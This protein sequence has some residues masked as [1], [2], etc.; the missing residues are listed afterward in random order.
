MPSGYA[1][2]DETMVRN[3]GRWAYIVA[4][5][6]GDAVLI[7]GAPS[8]SGAALEEALG[9]IWGHAK[10]T[11]EHG[12]YPDWRRQ[13]DSV[14]NLRSAEE[15]V[16]VW[17]A[18]FSEHARESGIDPR[19]EFRAV[20]R[21]VIPPASR[22]DR[23]QSGHPAR[24]RRRAAVHRA[25][26]GRRLRRRPLQGHLLDPTRR[27][28]CLP[29]SYRPSRLPP[30]PL[31]GGHCAQ[32]G[33]AWRGKGRRGPPPGGAAAGGAGA[34]ANHGSRRGVIV[35][36][37]AVLA[38]AFVGPQADP[39]RDRCVQQGLDRVLWPPVHLQ[40]QLVH[41]HGAL[42]V[43]LGL[44]RVTCAVLDGYG[45]KHPVRIRYENA[46]PCL[47]YHTQVDGMPA[48]S[49]DVERVIRNVAKRYMDAHVQFRGP[50][51]LGVES[52][53]MTIAANARKR[54]MSVGRAVTYALAD[55]SWSI[56]DG[57]P[58][59]ESLAWMPPG[60]EARSSGAG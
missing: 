6:S 41:Q 57:P 55:P 11:D 34:C 59:G 50:R 44:Q 10:V 26:Q 60:G 47:F 52:R 21:A 33:G 27:R 20:E 17:L 38:A 56:L 31:A 58:P 35:I 37:T 49:N 22:H 8:R 23:A 28:L 51:G 36:V 3:A 29:G 53:K 9:P 24:G 48:H 19:A 4:A 42:I 43:A 54:G 40:G 14:H 2:I 7:T 45:G 12:A 30:P 39:R 15:S 18:L 16:Y 32:R 5:C 1:A 25:S 46:M 13:S